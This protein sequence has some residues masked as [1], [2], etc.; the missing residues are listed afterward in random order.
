MWPPPPKKEGMRRVRLS[1]KL[2]ETMDVEVLGGLKN[3]LYMDIRENEVA[4]E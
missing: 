3:Y 1:E 4:L 2:A